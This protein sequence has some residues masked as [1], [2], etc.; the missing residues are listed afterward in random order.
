MVR[1]GVYGFLIRHFVAI[2]GALA[3]LSYA[4]IYSRQ[5]APA[6]IRSD[7]YSY[8]VY[9]PSWFLHGDTTLDGVARTLPG[10]EYPEFTAIRRWPGT[11]RWV[12]PHPMGPAILIAPFFFVAHALTRLLHAPP[13]G[14]SS[15][16][17][18]AAGL[19]GLVYLLAGLAVVRRLLLR[20]FSPAVALATLATVTWGT[21][22]FHYG[23]YDSVFSHIYSF[24]LVAVLVA[25]TESWWATPTLARSV[26]LGVTAAAIVLT[27]HINVLFVL[28]VPLYG[29]TSW[30][31]L[32]D[33]A[34]SLMLRWRQ[35]LVVAGSG[36]AGVL[37]Q[38]LLYKSATGLWLPSPYGAI[39]AGFTFSS[40][41]LYD[42]LFGTQ[43]GLFFWHPALLFAVAGWIVARGWASSLV[44]AAGI[45]LTINTLLI[46]S[47][48]DWQFGGSY[49]HRGF[50]DGFVLAAVFMAVFYAWVGGLRHRAAAVGVTAAFATLAVSLSVAQMIQYWM[51]VLPIA[52]TTW[53]QYRALF[54]RFQ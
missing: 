28:I 5:G 49:G 14:F 12:D 9:L 6:P 33:R 32:R 20:H 50:T 21:N 17:Q 42:V 2:A 45:V 48:F 23:V 46:A 4:A 34:V 53:D 54:L 7:G 25:C 10:G 47:W 52:N 18:H 31:S 36:V 35:L 11:N 41:H 44:L 13:D 51:G 26:G 24:F 15:Y 29:V 16:Y 8:Y 22:L 1:G 40:P 30:P 37:P 43:K 27:R 39:D 38:L 3:L 19:A